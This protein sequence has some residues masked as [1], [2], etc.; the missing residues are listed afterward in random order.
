MI[1][2]MGSES[3]SLLLISQGAQGATCSLSRMPLATRR[4]IVVWLTLQLLFLTLF[5]DPRSLLLG[6]CLE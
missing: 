3:K 5:R 4:L 1:V 6:L 2:L